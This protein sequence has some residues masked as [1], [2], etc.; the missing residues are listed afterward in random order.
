MNYCWLARYSQK[1][2]DGRLVR[3]HLIPRQQ[4]RAAWRSAHHPVKGQRP[5][6][7][8]PAHE[9]LPFKSLRHLIDDPRTW[10]WGCGG[11]MGNGGHHGELDQSRTIRVPFADLPSPLLVVAEELN[12]TWWLEREYAR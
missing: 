4:L 12:L 10:V 6:V 7:S 3:C 11:P 1:P 8:L 2:C 9:P 5:E